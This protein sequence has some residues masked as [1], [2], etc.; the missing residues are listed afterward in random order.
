LLN[1]RTRNLYAF[2]NEGIYSGYEWCM[3]QNKNAISVS[4]AS[5]ILR[6]KKLFVVT[7]L[8]IVYTRDKL[9]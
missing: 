5:I 2:F 4:L 6:L 3:K 8:S 7:R 1:K 9:A